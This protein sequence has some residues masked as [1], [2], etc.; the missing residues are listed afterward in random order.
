MAAAK[1]MRASLSIL[2]LV[3]VRDSLVES[4]ATSIAKGSRM[5]QE[6][7]VRNLEINVV[8]GGCQAFI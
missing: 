7:D 8:E 1:A 2:N 3:R 5:V 4:P 6:R